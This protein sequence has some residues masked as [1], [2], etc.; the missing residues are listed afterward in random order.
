MH[1]L[2]WLFINITISIFIIS[3]G[4]HLWNYVKDTY[5]VKKTKDLVNIQVE[6]YKKM[7]QELQENQR[8]FI[9]DNEKDILDQR[10]TEFILQGADESS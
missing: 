8:T 1:G 3:V 6:K 9:N 10:L 2:V 7:M 4:H 5:S